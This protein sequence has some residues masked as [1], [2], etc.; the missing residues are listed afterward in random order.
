MEG[1]LAATL[2]EAALLKSVSN[3][4]KMCISETFII[5]FGEV[6]TFILDIDMNLPIFVPKSLNISNKALI[7][8]ILF[9][10]KR[11]KVS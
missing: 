2:P 8:S 11:V 10:L 9:H 4:S 6:P 7:Q 5:C 1:C 3:L